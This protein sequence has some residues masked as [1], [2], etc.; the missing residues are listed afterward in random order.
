MLAAQVELRTAYTFDCPECGSENFV[1]AVVAELSQEEKQEL[2]EDFGVEGIVTGDLVAI[3]TKVTC[4]HCNRSFATVDPR[5][6]AR[7]EE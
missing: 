5:S 6:S 7:R 3:P 2:A 4:Q 1:R